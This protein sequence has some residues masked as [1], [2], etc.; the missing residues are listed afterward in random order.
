M[1]NPPVKINLQQ[2][3]GGPG[4]NGKFELKDALGKN[5]VILGSNDQGGSVNIRATDNK[6]TIS[7]KGAD[8]S[9]NLGAKDNSGSL[10]V[11]DSNNKV[12]VRLDG[13]AGDIILSNAD[14]AEEFD[15]APDEQI[16]PGMVMV[17][18]ENARLR[19]SRKAYD[20]KVAGVISGGGSYKPGI[21]LD[22]KEDKQG[23][24]PL[25]LMGKVHCRVDA[26]Y[27]HIGVGDLLTTSDTLGHA[28]RAENPI[29]AFGAVIG[30]ALAPLQQGQS[31]IPILVALQ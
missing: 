1:L 14:C 16:E 13:Q 10:T 31:S 17:F 20:K 25:A 8:A 2:L 29:D 22:R 6:P 28:M 26:S 11:R 15:I 27:G 4:K 21:I 7:I 19:P 12:T 18:D 30:K 5:K 23:R 9:M 24:E 3:L